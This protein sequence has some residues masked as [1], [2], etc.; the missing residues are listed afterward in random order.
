MCS[1]TRDNQGKV[2]PLKYDAENWETTEN[3]FELSGDN[4]TYFLVMKYA[5][6]YG[7]DIAESNWDILDS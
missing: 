5:S 7:D 4:Y 6:Y 2:N 1:N 3:S